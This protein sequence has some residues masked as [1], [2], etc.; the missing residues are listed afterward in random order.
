MGVATGA[1]SGFFVLDVDGEIGVESLRELEA[2]HGRLPDTVEQITGSGGR[3][4]LFGYPPGVS[5]GNKVALLPGLDV[6]GDGGY[7]VVAPSVHA[8][9]RKYAWEA[10]SRPDQVKLADPPTWLLELI[11][12]VQRQG[13]ARSVDEWRKLVSEGVCEGQRNSAIASLAGHLFRHYVDPYI[14]LD[15]LLC[16]NRVRC[17]PPL[18]DEETIATVDS[19]AKLEARRRRRE[20]KKKCQ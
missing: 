12:P 2:R 19:I 18:S 10:S 16:W 20:V 6:R 13:L 3:H 17:Y 7:I 14:V 9:G 4:I 8:S 5:I 11:Q 1:A 15:L